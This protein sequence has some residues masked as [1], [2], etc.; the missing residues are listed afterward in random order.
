MLSQEACFYGPPEKYVF[1]FT[2]MLCNHQ[3]ILWL[4]EIAG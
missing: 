2:I 4:E 3:N 1:Y